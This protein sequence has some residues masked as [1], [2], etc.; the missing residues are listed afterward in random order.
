MASR[1]TM[2]PRATSLWYNYAGHLRQMRIKTYITIPQAFRMYAT[3]VT[4][5]AI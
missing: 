5:K 1:D 4:E 2:G 3:S